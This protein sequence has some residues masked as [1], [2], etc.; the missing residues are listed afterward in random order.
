MHMICGAL[1]QFACAILFCSMIIIGYYMH[2]YVLTF[3][4]SHVRDVVV[5]HWHRRSS[6]TNLTQVQDKVV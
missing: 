4:S 6:F 5:V 2:M 3:D 1:V